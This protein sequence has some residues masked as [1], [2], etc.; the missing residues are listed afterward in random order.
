MVVD[1]NKF[2]STNENTSDQ[3]TGWEDVAA[4]A[5]RM[6]SAKTEK[7]QNVA[8]IPKVLENTA[9]QEASRDDKT[10]PE[11]VESKEIDPKVVSKIDEYMMSNLETGGQAEKEEM[12]DYVADFAGVAL[13]IKPAA[14]VVISSTNMNLETEQLATM[15]KEAGLCITE[16]WKN[17]RFFISRSQETA[18]QISSEF[19]KLWED[20]KTPET[21]RAIGKLLGYPETA[22]NQ[23]FS[24]PKSGLFAKLKRLRAKKVRPELEWHYVHN[25]E[26]Q[27]EEFEM[28]EKPLHE[29]MD[30]NCPVA[31]AV[32]KA[33][34]TSSGKPKKWL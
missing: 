20:G 6:R 22:I 4:M 29:Y 5:N 8:P 13:G 25:P 14:L 33:E 30:T 26:Y 31:A 32:L 21:D 17:G 15:I 9:E 3:P 23:D 2:S 18:N 24:Q 27:D 12:A 7:T 11:I 28:F 34:K 10:T 19:H 16:E 1:P